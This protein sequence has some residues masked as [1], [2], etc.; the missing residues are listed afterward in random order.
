MLFPVPTC[1]RCYA[2]S[3]IVRCAVLRQRMSISLSVYPLSLPIAPPNH[4]SSLLSL[5]LPLSPSLSPSLS[6]L[7]LP[8]SATVPFQA[9]IFTRDLRP[10]HVLLNEYKSGQG[11]M[12]HQ[13]TL[14]LS[15]YARPMH[16]PLLSNPPPYARP[17]RYPM[18]YA[19]CGTEAVLREG[20]AVCG[21]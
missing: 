21:V 13:V 6:L 1:V 12:P 15:P 3:G 14:T 17:M 7:S 5:S 18:R 11:I 10:N 2:L 9:G 4:P 19:V 20:M 8:L 16:C